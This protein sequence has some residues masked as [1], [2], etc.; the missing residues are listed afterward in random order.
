MRSPCRRSICRVLTT[1]APIACSRTLS[2]TSH[3]VERDIGLEQRA[4]HLAHRGIDVGFRQRPA[5]RQPIE[6]ATKF[7]RQIVGTRLFFLLPHP[8][9]QAQPASRRV[10]I[11]RRPILRDAASRLLGMRG[12]PN[13][14]APEGAS[15]CRAVDLRPQ[16]PGG[17]SKRTSFRGLRALNSGKPQKSR[18]VAGKW[19]FCELR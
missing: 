6:N 3:H 15:R 2:V 4:A 13:N 11:L 16:G 9:E 5:P 12:I 17:G 8:E 10:A 19:H 7:F 1:V 14:F 18:K